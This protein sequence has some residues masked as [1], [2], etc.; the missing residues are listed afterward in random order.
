MPVDRLPSREYI[1]RYEKSTF[2]NPNCPAP[3]GNIAAR[4][5]TM[6]RVVQIGDR[7]VPVWPEGQKFDTLDGVLHSTRF[8]DIDLYHPRLKQVILDR[9]EK[10]LDTKRHGR[11]AC[12]TKVHHPERWGCPEATLLHERVLEFFRRAIKSSNAVADHAWANVYRN[13][14]YCMSHSHIRA[15][16]SFVYFLDSGDV[17]PADPESGQFAIRDPRFPRCC[18]LGDGC[19]TNSILCDTTPGSLVMFPGEVVHGV[20]PYHGVR[21]RITMSWNVNEQVIPGSPFIPGT[22]VEVVAD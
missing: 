3:H 4:K 19:V 21:P 20:N 15:T 5:N 14:D 13:G 7:A 6:T 16:A 9:V 22:G 1:T 10:R 8:T 18:P 17:D 2:E 12:G 11:S